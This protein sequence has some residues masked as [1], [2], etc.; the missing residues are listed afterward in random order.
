MRRRRND[1]ASLL[2]SSLAFFAAGLGYI[3]RQTASSARP[4]LHY[5]TSLYHAASHRLYF[6]SFATLLTRSHFSVVRRHRRLGRHHL[7]R[8]DANYHRGVLAYIFRRPVEA[9]YFTTRRR[10][11]ARAAVRHFVRRYFWAR[12]SFA[13]ARDSGNRHSLISASAI[14]AIS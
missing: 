2:S 14:F 9:K 12:Y 1:A 10:H 13:E 7:N 3:K 8:D 4:C 6:I 11:A 5:A